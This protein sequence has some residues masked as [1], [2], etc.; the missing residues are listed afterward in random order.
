MLVAWEL[1]EDSK[2]P[3][4][5]PDLPKAVKYTS[6]WATKDAQQIKDSKIFWILMEMNIRMAINRKLWL[7]PTMFSNL[8]GYVA[9]K[10]DF[11]HVPIRARKDLA[12]KWYDLPYLE[13]YDTLDA[14]LD[15]WLAQ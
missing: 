13:M 6:L 2:F 11:H 3:S 5:A 10:V 9:F 14:V 12:Q 8:Q 7:L 4:V 1:P 15:R